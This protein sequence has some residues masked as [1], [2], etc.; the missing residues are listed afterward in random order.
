MDNTEREVISFPF[1]YKEIESMQTVRSIRQQEGE[2]KELQRQQKIDDKLRI[3]KE[4]R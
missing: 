2:D 4:R 3:E 1:Q